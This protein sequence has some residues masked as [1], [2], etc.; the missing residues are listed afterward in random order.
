MNQTCINERITRAQARQDMKERIEAARL[1]GMERYMSHEK[2]K[3]FLLKIGLAKYE[4][5]IL[6]V[7]TGEAYA[8]Q[9]GVKTKI[10]PFPGGKR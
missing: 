4:K 1:K 10:I 7:E 8:V 6:P 3:N 2:F 9:T 5:V